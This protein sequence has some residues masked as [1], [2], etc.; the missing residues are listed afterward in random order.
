MSFLE[1]LS[2]FGTSI[3]YF[4]VCVHLYVITRIGSQDDV[5]FEYKETNMQMSNPLY[6][7]NPGA[8]GEGDEK[9]LSAMY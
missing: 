1:R 3:G 8:I 5:V 4:T 2:F 6:E 7:Q 9:R